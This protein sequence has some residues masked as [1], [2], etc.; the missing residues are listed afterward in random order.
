[1]FVTRSH[2]ETLVLSPSKI[3]DRAFPTTLL[4]TGSHTVN[5]KLLVPMFVQRLEL[6]SFFRLSRR[7]R[8]NPYQMGNGVHYQRER[9]KNDRPSSL[10]PRKRNKGFYRQDIS[11]PSGRL[12]PRMVRLLSLPR[13]QRGDSGLQR[14]SNKCDE[15]FTGRNKTAISSFFPPAGPCVRRTSYRSCNRMSVA[16]NAKVVIGTWFVA[17]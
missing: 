17:N 15:L 13:F 8:H 12:I 2:K 9:K 3:D 5:T 4:I 14:K 6:A 10:S 1:M 7:R 16:M 11:L